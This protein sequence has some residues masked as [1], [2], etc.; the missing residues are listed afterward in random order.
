MAQW[1]GKGSPELPKLDEKKNI[2]KATFFQKWFAF[3]PTLPETVRRFVS[4][5]NG[6]D[7][8]Q[9]ALAWENF[10]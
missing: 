2:K 7:A 1:Y 10:G 9:L 4:A 6:R 5:K 3:L 8:M